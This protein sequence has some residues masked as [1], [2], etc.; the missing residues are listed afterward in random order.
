MPGDITAGSGT[1]YFGTSLVNAVNS[2]AVPMSRL[3]DMA[4]RILAGW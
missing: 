2:G 1:S 3:N 4:T